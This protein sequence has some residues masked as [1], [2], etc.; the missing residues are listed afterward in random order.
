[1]IMSVNSEPLTTESKDELRYRV[2]CQEMGRECLLC[3]QSFPASGFIQM[4]QFF[5]S[6]GQS[7]GVPALASVLPMNIQD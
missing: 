7:I 1:M 2:H 3:L 5:T 6:G 4:N